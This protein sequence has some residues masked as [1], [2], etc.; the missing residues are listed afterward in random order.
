M[1]GNSHSTGP[2]STCLC[3]IALSP[4]MAG[5]LSF[6]HITIED[7]LSQSAV[8]CILQ[9]Q[10]GFL[11]FGTADGLN[12]FD[13]YTF[14]VYRHSPS[15][16]RTLSNNFIVRLLE[17]QVGDL[18]VAPRGVLC[19]L[20][21]QR[22][23]FERFESS[24]QAIE[25]I[26]EDRQGNLW[27]SDKNNLIRVIRKSDR[28]VSFENQ[29]LVW[30]GETQKHV[31]PIAED[32]NGVLWV[33]TETGL[34]GLGSQRK[35]AV[36]FLP[37]D[38]FSPQL[39]SILFPIMVADPNEPSLL[40]IASFG[41]GLVRLNPATG[42]MTHFQNDPLDKHSLANDFVHQIYATDR[43]ALWFATTQGLAR[44]D[45][46]RQGFDHFQRRTGDD[47]SLSLNDIGC[48]YSDRSNV[49]WVGTLG[50]GLNKHD[51]GRSFGLKRQLAGH[52]SGLNHNM[53]LAL[54][55]PKDK[56]GEELWIGTIKGLSKWDRKSD[57]LVHYQP[58]PEKTDSL[59]HQLVRAIFIDRAGL[60]WVGTDYGLNRMKKDG[61][62]FLHYLKDTR[63]SRLTKE[64][65]NVIRE[66]GKG[67]LWVGMARGLIRLDSNT[68]KSDNSVPRLFIA[69]PNKPDSLNDSF[70]KT[71][72]YDETEN[73]LWVG[74]RKGLNRMDLGQGLE[75]GF[76]NYLHDP[77]NP[78]SLSQGY[79]LS[80]CKDTSGT[81]WIGTDGGGLNKMRPGGFDH[82]RHDQGLPND[83]IYS[84]TEDARGHLWLS[85]NKGLARFDPQQEEVRVYDV[86]DGL[87]SN[88]FNTGASFESPS[89]EIFLGGVKGFNYFF[90]ESIRDNRV[91]PSVVITDLLLSNEVVGLGP[92]S[93]LKTTIENTR[94]LR[95]DHA[96]I[97]SLQFSGLHF[98]APERNR[99]A[100]RL[101][102]FNDD[103]MLTGAD[104]RIATYTNLNP[105]EYIFEV[106]AANKDGVWNE[107]PVSLKITIPPP[108]SQ[109]W[110]AYSL[111]GLAF[112]SLVGLYLHAQ[113][114]KLD[115]ARQ[116]NEKLHQLDRLKDEANRSLEQKVE[117]RTREIVVTQKKLVETA[118][119]AGMAE[120]A[121]EVIHN[122]GNTL[123]SAKVSASQ[124]EE[125]I[126]SRRY[127]QLLQNLAIR[128]QD[129]DKE[130][131]HTNLAEG[132]GRIYKGL[133]R[134]R[135]IINE[136]NT[137]LQYYLRDIDR[138][139]AEQRDYA[140]TAKASERVA[141][142]LNGL[143][144]ETLEMKHTLFEQEDVRVEKELADLPLVYLDEAR[145]KRVLF[146]L[147]NNAREAL[148]EQ[149]SGQA[150]VKICSMFD[151]ERVRV[152][153]IDNGIGI[154]PTQ[155][156]K[157]FG[158]GFSTKRNYRG[159]GLHYC[160]NAIK[161]MKGEIHIDSEG[162]NKGTTV[163][164]FFPVP[165]Q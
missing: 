59:N 118:R 104:Q 41:Q 61:S 58:D 153:L 95:L 15:D 28:S 20:D 102:G 114:R 146:Y 137:R 69:D 60:I 24:P 128:L 9:D 34:F 159:F 14:K 127:H 108:L 156:Q 27:L 100:H 165:T 3:L 17:D 21:R 85:T 109:T 57:R 12:R 30:Q 129:E 35:E 151:G 94:E 52:E 163:S 36:Q 46:T 149:N 45:P 132:L 112:V 25:N 141:L 13:G 92:D 55:E 103:W 88:E 131:N 134:H 105:G 73:Q 123:N 33:M 66:D 86:H 143:I 144:E 96:P 110:W 79:V 154:S 140:E 82:Y 124:I 152:N 98:A 10:V 81:L 42:V 19:R 53:V 6:E 133:E 158:R 67:N 125:L 97:F 138:A 122:V 87:Q 5:D 121:T 93:P 49:F 84:V 111:Y 75:S 16:E 2:L 115:Q 83:T 117:S 148:S 47:K 43:G 23:D 65:V 80:F 1:T 48:M 74:T 63:E 91:A 50:G 22:G 8:L 119:M 76:S 145:F 126:E 120:I 26:Y 77:N 31:G 135:Q 150:K 18:W 70:V 130:V 157:V 29:P 40:W 89:G 164:L 107:Q 147:L 161:E 99:Y 162:S 155:I 39:D 72:F 68:K 136:E 37:G 11:W 160:A 90:P 32:G 54:A 116:L 106:K 56:A 64:R 4:L 71:L 101:M 62:G 44:F 51:P 113:R 38:T 139:L 7:G 142:D 78:D